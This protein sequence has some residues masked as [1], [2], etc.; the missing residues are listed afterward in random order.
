V[1]AL[2]TPSE[3]G[4]G[5]P[6]HGVACSFLQNS[7]TTPSITM[8]NAEENIKWVDTPA[9]PAPSAPEFDCGVRTTLVSAASLQSL[10]AT[11]SLASH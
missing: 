2:L 8:A 10:A 1:L 3:L 4:T 5:A 7:P 6:L 11:T 9:A